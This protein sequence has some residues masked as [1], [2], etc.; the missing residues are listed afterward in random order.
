MANEYEQQRRKKAEA[1]RQLGLDPFGHRYPDTIGTAEAL[2]R[3]E[4]AGEGAPATVAGRLTALR[5]FGKLIFAD[6]RDWTG[7]L[8]MAFNKKTLAPELWQ[9][10]KLLDLGDWV[11]A[12][13]RLIKT[14]TG[15]ITLDVAKLEVL[16]KALLPPPEKWHGLTDVEARYRQRYVDLFANPEVRDLFLRRSLLMH[17]LRRFLCER[18]FVEVETPVLQPIYGGA[19]ARPFI[20][21]HNT[22]DVDLYLRISPELYLKRLLVGGMERV[23]EI[24]RVFRNEGISTRHNPE[25]TLMELYQAFGDYHDMM[26]IV[27]TLVETL[28]RA[29][30]GGKTCLPFQDK[31]IEYKAPWRRAL[32]ADLLEEHA[33]VRLGD[34]AAIRAKARGLGLSESNKHIDVVTHDVFEATVEEH[35]IQP[36]FVLDWP[37]RLCPLTKRKAGNP[38]IAER[39][40]PMMAGMEIGNAYTELNDPDVQLEAFRLQLAGQTETMAVMD[41]DFVEAL[42]HGMPPAG[43]LGLGIDRLVMLLTNAPSIRDVILFPALRPKGAAGGELN[44]E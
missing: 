18:G 23:F 3:F 30:S 5:E 34:E 7:R 40:E 42:K 35:L 8:Q 44:V 32:Y 2:K 20:T 36:T 15:E 41:E 28:A 14:R 11:G 27:E 6:L 38:A 17:E 9:R 16:A 26:E 24:S 10:V 29:I 31:M 37:A 43:G 25:F 22:L 33:G 12:E 19:A 1:L 39:F 4:A 21:H 13:G